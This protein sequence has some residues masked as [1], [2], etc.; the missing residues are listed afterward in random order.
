MTYYQKHIE[1][2][3][4]RELEDLQIRRLREV[5]HRAYN[6]VPFYREKFKKAG[7]RP[8]DIKSY[9]D[10][11]KVPF[12]TKN[13]LRDHYPF[14]LLAV[15]LADCIELHASSGTTGKP[16]VV[17]YT[18]HDMEVWGEVMA[19]CLAMAGLT[20]NDVFQNPIPYGT[21]TGAFGFHYGAQRIGAL[22]V[23]TGKGD[24]E[25][26]IQ[27]MKDF[28]TTF[29]SGVV[30]YAIHLGNVALRM[31]I[32]PAKDLKV[33]NG[34]FGAEFFS[35]E[36]KKKLS[37]MWDMDVHDIY[38]L[39]EMCGPG[40]SADCDAHDGLH[41]WEDHFL[42][43]VIDPDTGERLERE[44]EGELVLTTLSKEGM[45][46]IRYRTRDITFIYDAKSCDC[47]R[48]HLRHAPIKGRTDDMFIVRGT[49]IFPS[50]IEGAIMGIP[51]VGGNYRIVLT[52]EDD[53]DQ[54]IIEVESDK[55]VSDDEK[56]VIADRIKKAVRVVTTL[57]PRV[58]VVDPGEIKHQ[59][60]KA[61]RVIDLRRR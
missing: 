56:R 10:L 48:T 58:M 47:G 33:R 32:D 31:G 54:M 37:Q 55:V 53:M 52:T 60:I 42:A 13:D 27:L 41:L 35:T 18:P 61:R 36:M 21:F 5:V 20:K 9:D 25:R 28:G 38:G 57:T 3:P 11:A 6:S 46:M 7:I 50:A 59:G 39:T 17:C 19:R 16:I 14:G 49:N 34:I 22:V 45:P 43:E 2:M 15:S 51:G 29:I 12:T 30:S 4:R 1:T 44:E 8:E 40:V 23:P 24:S 26:Q